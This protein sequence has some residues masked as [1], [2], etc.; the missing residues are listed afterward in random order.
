[1]GKC[2]NPAAKLKKRLTIQNIVYV[3]DGQGGFTQTWADSATVWASLDPYKGWERFQ[4]NQTATPI[5]HKIEMRYTPLLTTASRLVYGDR[6][7]EVKEALNRNEDNRFL[8][9]RAIELE[10]VEAEAETNRILLENG[11]ALLLE[12]NSNL[13]LEAA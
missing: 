12:D 8:D 13:L 3:A 9:I 11:F 4:A 10:S 7:F 2:D 6:V 5:T 1:L